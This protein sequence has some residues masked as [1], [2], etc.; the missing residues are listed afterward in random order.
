[1]ADRTAPVVL[2]ND[3]EQQWLE[4]AIK[5]RLLRQ[6]DFN[7]IEDMQMG[8]ASGGFGM[9]HAGN[10]RGIRVAVK[11]LFNPADF[12]QEVGIHKLVQDSDNIVKFYGITRMKGT[13]DYGMVLKFAGKGS[14]RDYL[15]RHFDS[16]DWD[17]KMRLA[18]DVAA[19]ISFIHQD[20]IC[21]HDLHSRNVLIDQTGKALITDFGLSRYVNHANSNNGVRGVVPYISPERLKNAPFDHSSDV[22]SLGVIMWELTSGYPPFDRDGENFLLPFQIMRGRREEIVPG[23]PVEYST[24]YQQCWDDEPHNRPSLPLILSTLD[25]MLA[26]HNGI[27]AEENGNIQPTQPKDLS[28]PRSEPTETHTAPVVLETLRNSEPISQVP[29]EQNMPNTR[30]FSKCVANVSALVP[31]HALSRNHSNTVATPDSLH[32]L[33]AALPGRLFNLKIS[34]D[35]MDKWVPPTGTRLMPTRPPWIQVTGAGV[36]PASAGHH[37]AASPKAPTTS[38]Q[39]SP[40]SVTSRLPYGSP[41]GSRH[42][43]KDVSLSSVIPEKMAQYDDYIPEKGTPPSLPSVM[44]SPAPHLYYQGLQKQ[45]QGYNQY[46]PFPQPTLM[47]PQSQGP[48]YNSGIYPPYGYSPVLT[49]VVPPLAIPPIVIPPKSQPGSRVVSKSTQNWIPRDNKTKIKDFFMACRNGN[50]EA[51]RWHLAH[52]ANVMEPYENMSGRTPLHAAAM[53]DSCE[54]MKL[55]CESAGPQLNLN[56]LDDG[57]Q[58]PLHLLTH[59]GRECYELLVY[60]LKMGANPNAQDS[61]RRTPLMTTFI[62][63][64]NA[65]V[66]ETLLDYGADPNIRCRENNAL[67]EAAIRLR[68]HCV[69]V[70]LDTDLSMSEQSS[71]EHAMDVCYRVTESVNRNQVLSLLVRWKNAEGIQKRQTLATMILKGSL[72][73]G[74]RRI[75]QRRIARQVLTAASPQ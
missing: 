67:A 47:E 72:Q 64:D 17:N 31:K 34:D 57:S 36:G 65:L 58:T 3:K 56:E 49:P 8:I 44:P 20:K 68:Y 32:A 60:M 15:S 9:I 55:L 66:V 16:L 4:G 2:L 61:E 41:D 54:V 11:V 27:R 48:P 75:D 28:G 45:H 13:G 26:V 63:N 62:L 59:Y 33:D 42:S 52:G 19:G 30:G 7:E 35:S 40:V 25:A 18:R 14:L 50:L 37:R 38:A 5:D 71:L 73:F 24:L 46:P 1:M 39:H 51:V 21:H 6:I 74:E 23:T 70:L 69:K 29:F 10:W 22:Y 43:P 12:I 53:S